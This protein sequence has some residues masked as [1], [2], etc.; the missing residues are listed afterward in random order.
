[1]KKEGTKDREMLF[2]VKKRIE[3]VSLPDVSRC[4]NGGDKIHFLNTGSSDAILLESDGRFAMIDSGE[5]TDNPRGFKHLELDGYEQMVLEYLKSHA[6]GADGKV[7]LDFILGTHS[8]SDHIGGFDTIIAD[9]DI[10]IEKAF[11]KVYDSSKIRLLEIK[12]WD[13]T[14]VYNQMINALNA[15]NIPIIS[16]MDGTPFKFGNLTLTFF[17]TKD[18]V[19]KRKVGE[20][21]QSYGVL[22]EKN[23]T[24]VFLSGDIDNFTGDES[25]LA[26]EI[27]KVDLLKVGH[28]FYAMSSTKKFIQT[29]CPSVC[30]VTNKYKSVDMITLS[31]INRICRPDIYI[32]GREDGVLALLGDNGE[33]KY[34]NKL[35]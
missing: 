31:R 20:N 11:L 5:D 35:H 1:M 8:H 19:T 3:S 30:V 21:D 17:N 10:I 24:R 2:E 27:G 23:G 7:H 15:K 29:L 26:P 28:H 16:D 25:R 6:S 22:V 14:E 32:T 12:M 13:N 34:Y 9:D 4:E 18:P 33:I